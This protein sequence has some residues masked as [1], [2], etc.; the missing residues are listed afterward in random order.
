MKKI[1]RLGLLI[2]IA[3][4]GLV[5]AQDRTVTGKVT[6]AEDNEGIPG[7]A[8]AVK[9][10]TVGTISAADGSFSL[11]VPQNAVLI[12]TSVGFVTQQIEV[13]SKTAIDLQMAPDVKQLSE[14][15]VVGYGTQTK[16]SFTGA[17]TTITGSTIK[18]RPVQ[19]FAQALT[20]S[21]A[22]VNI[23]QPNGVLNNP[24]VIRIRGINSI[25]LSSFPL[26]VIDGIPVATGDISNNSAANNPLADIN[27]SDIESIDILK[28]AASTSIYGSRGAA[29]VLIITTK[30]GKQGKAKLTYDGWAG[31]NKVTRL[32][33]LLDAQQYMDYKN[34][35]MRNALVNNPALNASSFPR[36]VDG[37]SFFPSYNADGSLVNT[38]WFDQVYRVAY[39][40]NHALSVSGGNE[41]TN[42]YFSTGITKQ[43]GF[44]KNNEFDRKNARLN[45]T[46]KATN[47]LTLRGNMTFTNSFNSAPN[48]GSLAGQAYNSSG[49]AR[50][51]LVLPPNVSPRNADGTYNIQTDNTIGDGANLA[52][53]TFQNPLPLLD[54]NKITSE[55][56]RVLSN[57]GIDLNLY[58][59]LT[60]K[61]TYSLDKY[62]VENILFYSPLHGDGFTAGGLASNQQ[63]KR[64]NWNW[65]NTL[66]YETSVADKHNFGILIGSDVQKTITN[67]WG[68]QRQTL[69]DPFFN[70][71]QAGYVTDLSAGNFNGIKAIESYLTSANYN[72]DKKYYISGN[73]RRD[74]LSALAPEHRWGTFGGISAGW[75]ISQ[76]GFFQNMSFLSNVTNLKLKASW[77]KVGNS[78]LNSDFGSLSIFTTGNYGATPTLAY[79]QAGNPLLS[80]ES[81]TQTN[82]GFDLGLLQDRIQVELNYYNNDIS[83]LILDSPQ[84]P[85][86]G[87]PGNSI[88]ENVGSMYNRGL[89]FTVT[90]T[91]INSGKFK[92][93]TN[94][95]FTTNKNEVTHLAKGDAPIRGFNSGL[96]SSNITAVGHPVGSIYVVKTN[97]I[98]PANGRRIYVNA[99][100]QEVQYMHHGGAN[101]WTFLDDTPT[102]AVTGNDASVYYNALPTWFGGFR[103]TLSYGNLELNLL[104]TYSGGNY[105]Y[106][107]TQSGLRDQ[108]FWNNH[109]DVLRRWTESGQVTDIPRAVFGD[110]I[111]N[112]TAIPMDAN[113]EKGDYMRLQNMVLGYKVP[114]NIFGKSGISSVR[115]YG[116]VDNV[117]LLTKYSGVD[118]EISSNGNSNIAPGVERNT[119][120]QSRTFTMGINVGF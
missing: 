94:F 88:L 42:Y 92:W 84:T 113:V 77:G 70:T 32:P 66:Q 20:G 104:F 30:K 73:L 46:H 72:F 50:L 6:S 35:A 68:A 86:K 4:T 74:G 67:G 39:S 90:A 62:N 47:W 29:G 116:Q 99:A 102:S 18:D 53:I 34:E 83:G 78:N 31:M 25:S 117:L 56:S 60:F 3:C 24:P 108:R 27:P 51:P 93:T 12:F 114:A 115:V 1:L 52:P 80:W 103:N 10:T 79:S 75:M 21:A 105:I 43:Q 57:M 5:Q 16:K 17:A 98:N 26:I 49:L 76:E 41:S 118:P 19:S 45:I 100:G 96:E 71:F 9:G 13:G 82:I 64:E 55:T 111:S 44:I 69:S 23:V 48:T 112:G 119:V 63:I 120:P 61:T 8:I 89:E 2:L 59:G 106:N 54:N 109:T 85:S 36:D 91:P 28:D 40:Q 14:V 15:V 110:N 38:N 7:V 107:G 65:V 101:A 95:N 22:G 97:G 58:K 33:D 11:S 37:N 87:I 81:S